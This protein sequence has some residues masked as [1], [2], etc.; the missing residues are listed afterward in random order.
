MKVADLLIRARCADHHEQ[1]QLLKTQEILLQKF[2]LKK[3]IKIR[4]T[5]VVH[6]PADAFHLPPWRNYLKNLRR[7]KTQPDYLL[8]TDWD[9]FSRRLNK[10]LPFIAE[11]ATIGVK[12]MSTGECEN[13][14]DLFTHLLSH[15]ILEDLQNEIS[16]RSTRIK[17][18]IQLARK[19]KQ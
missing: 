15:S 6:G 16:N 13:G 14:V 2:C 4:R 18:G 9:R 7:S 3:E 5:I 10:S 17:E 8:F 12:P 19:Y 1:E 11:L